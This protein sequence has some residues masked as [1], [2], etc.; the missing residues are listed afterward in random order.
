MERIM[1]TPAQ[2]LAHAYLIAAKAH[3]NQLDKGDRPYILHPIKVADKLH[4]DDFQKMAIGV[5]HDAVEDGD[6]TYQE[7]Y[8]LGFSER[9]I[10]GVRAMTR[11]PGQSQ[12]EY[13]EIVLANPDAVDVKIEDIDHN[14][15]LTRLKGLR[16][17]DFERSKKYV[18]FYVRLKAKQ[19]ENRLKGIL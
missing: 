3:L 10:N 13:E 19:K 11:I 7:L 15:R 18:K 12:E 16:D 4:T 6:V 2:E 17:K 1:L 8:D 5:L 9:V 14:S